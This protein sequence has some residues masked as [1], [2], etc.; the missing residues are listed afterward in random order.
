MNNSNLGIHDG[1]HFV[2][3]DFQDFVEEDSFLPSQRGHLY[4][5]IGGYP[6]GMGGQ[7][8]VG[9]WIGTT[10]S[11]RIM[12]RLAIKRSRMLRRRWIAAENWIGP[13]RTGVPM[14]VHAHRRLSKLSKRHFLQYLSHRIEPDAHQVLTFAEYCPYGS[15][16]DVLAEL[17]RIARANGTEPHHIPEAWLWFLFQELAEANHY[18]ANAVR[19]EDVFAVHCDLKP[20]NVFLVEPDNTVHEHRYY[21]IPKV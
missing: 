6:L 13:I 19:Q 17:R 20:D 9:L 12:K 21:P 8:M 14:G 3:E 16:D 4:K 5:W 7:G 11:G 10:R 1:V 18:M 15:L 2:A